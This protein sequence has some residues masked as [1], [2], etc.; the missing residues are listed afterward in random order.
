MHPLPSMVSLGDPRYCRAK[1]FQE[2]RP[3]EEKGEENVGAGWMGGGL[4]D[5]Q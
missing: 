2:L 1:K 4:G 3:Q 5:W